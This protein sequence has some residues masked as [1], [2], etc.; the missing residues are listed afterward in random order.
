M[1]A[2]DIAVF[3]FIFE[4]VLNLLANNFASDLG[5]RREEVIVANPGVDIETEIQ[6]QWQQ[7][8]TMASAAILMG[9]VA[10]AFLS[11]VFGQ[12]YLS[13]LLA[14]AGVVINFVPVLKQFVAAL[15]ILLISLGLPPTLAWGIWTI[16]NFLLVLMLLLWLTGKG[17]H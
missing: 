12:Y 6:K 17:G 10:G 11:A 16:Y 7:A 5:F 2:I 15:P 14:A 9:T 1:R 3:L 8:Q 13:L 4:F